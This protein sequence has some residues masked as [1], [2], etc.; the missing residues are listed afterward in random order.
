MEITLVARRLLKDAELYLG[1]I[2]SKAYGTP[3][4]IL[5]GATIGQHTRHFIEFFQCLVSQIGEPA[6]IIDY[7][8]RKRD[9]SI[10]SDPP[11]A[12]KAIEEIKAALDS[13]DTDLPCKLR[14]TEHFSSDKPVEVESNLSR[15]LLYNIEH[16]IHHLAIIKI[17]LATV[18][19]AIELPEHFGVAPS[20]VQHN[21]NICAQ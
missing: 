15:E 19:P 18:A 13:F 11:A 12:L 3:L 5:F 8:T 1:R 10:Q 6:R 9:A 4:E 14:C 2:D 20:T 7:A 21:Q 17:G 16:T